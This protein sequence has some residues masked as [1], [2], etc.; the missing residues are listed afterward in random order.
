MYAFTV[1]S[2]VIDFMYY[3]QVILFYLIEVINLQNQT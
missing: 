3:S 2:F 1:L